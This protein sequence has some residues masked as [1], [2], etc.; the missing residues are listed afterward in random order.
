M[1]FIAK[2]RLKI[3]AGFRVGVDFAAYM[4]VRLLVATIQTLPF[5]MGDSICRFLAWLASGPM[6]IRQKITERNLSRVFPEG[7]EASRKKLSFEMWH[8]LLLMVCEIAWAQRRLHRSNWSNHLQYRNNRK[9]LEL[10]LS[11][12]PVVIVTGHLG[13]FEIGGYQSGMMGLS[14]LSIAR[15]LLA[16]V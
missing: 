3:A 4:T 14:S 7:D 11:D 16:M 15:P 1:S 8:H 2:Q 12:R 9:M 13:N 6:G 10:M 5:D